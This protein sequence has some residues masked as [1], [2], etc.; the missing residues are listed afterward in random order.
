MGG[1]QPDRVGALLSTVDAVLTALKATAFGDARAG[2]EARVRARI[3][4]ARALG[5]LAWLTEIVRS[6]MR[7]LDDAD[8]HRSE[9]R[10]ST[11]H[12]LSIH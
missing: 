1:I 7:E 8:D 2:T 9:H 11:G 10:C 5:E 12:S 4:C 6:A 3:A